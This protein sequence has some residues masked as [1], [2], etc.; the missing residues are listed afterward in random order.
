MGSLHFWPSALPL[1]APH[2]NQEWPAEFETTLASMS[3]ALP[4]SSAVPLETYVD[5]VCILHLELMLILIENRCAAFWTSRCTG[6]E[7]SPFTCSSPSS[8]H[9]P[10]PTTLASRREESRAMPTEASLTH[11]SLTV[12]QVWLLGKYITY[13]LQVSGLH[14]CHLWLRALPRAFACSPSYSTPENESGKRKVFQSVHH[15][16][17]P[18]NKL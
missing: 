15:K 3:A 6:V 18:Q 12:G 16:R 13:K 4:D 8:S 14:L 10:A 5:L 17:M 9:S 7:S 1:Y 11:S 2:L